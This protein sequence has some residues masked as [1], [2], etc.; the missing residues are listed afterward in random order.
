MDSFL[1][2]VGGAAI[3]FLTGCVVRPTAPQ[4]PPPPQIIKIDTTLE[5]DELST[6]KLIRLFDPSQESHDVWFEKLSIIYGNLMEHYENNPL[7]I[8]LN[9]MRA[10]E[11][12][13]LHERLSSKYT[14]AWFR[15][16]TDSDG[17]SDV[18]SV[19]SNH[20]WNVVRPDKARSA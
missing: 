3:V 14:R 18:V 10:Y 11:I 13:D 15:A 1:R 6:T 19:S 5:D 16:E 9:Q 7:D 8:N 2:I 20:D 17:E 4:L 12:V